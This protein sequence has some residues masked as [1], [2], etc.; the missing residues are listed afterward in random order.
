[1]KGTYYKRNLEELA[2]S[3]AKAG[4]LTDAMAA[5]MNLVVDAVHAEAGVIW[6]YDRF[7]DGMIRP[8]QSYGGGNV[9]DIALRPG[10][11]VAGEVIAKRAPAIIADCKKDPRWTGKVDKL[12]GFDVKSMICIPLSL[13][14]LAFGC[15]QILNRTDGLS[16]DEKDMAF[17]EEMSKAAVSALDSH[18]FLDE[19]VQVRGAVSKREEP[20]FSELFAL[21]FFSDVEFQLRRTEDF[22]KMGEADKRSVLQHAQKIWQIYHKH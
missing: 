7:G 20:S 16:Y 13:R 19:L 17:A 11:S 4:N 18:G 22:S 6:F 8:L 21:R 5:F 2:G 10:E 9:K 1:M 15:I 12:T 3:I 14:D